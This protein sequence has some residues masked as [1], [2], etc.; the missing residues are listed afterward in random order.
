MKKLVS[1][2]VVMSAVAVIFPAIVSAQSAY[3]NVGNLGDNRAII[4]INSPDAREVTI[5]VSTPSELWHKETYAMNGHLTKIFD[6]SRLK[7]GDYE[8]SFAIGDEVYNRNFTKMRNTI[9][10]SSD[11]Y[12][13]NVIDPVVYADDDILTVSYVN[14]QLEEVVLKIYDDSG[15]SM[16]EASSSEYI[17]H[18]KLDMQRLPR[19]EY[20]VEL[21]TG[22]SK[23][24]NYVTV[25]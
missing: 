1:F 24:S 7:Y 23:V 3:I 25:R 5:K 18:E 19:G 11:S 16:Y 14:P 9:A 17:Y 22:K 6:F 4:D 8:M 2:F 13:G 21:K 15:N 10:W 20:R 12:V